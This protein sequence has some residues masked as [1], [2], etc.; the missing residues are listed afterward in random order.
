L[1]KYLR[2]IVLGLAILAG[3]LV[4]VYTAAYIYIAFNKKELILRIKQQAT[5]KLNGDIQIADLSLG[6]LSTFPH[7]S[8]LLENVSV[9][10][11]LFSQHHHPFFAA[12][13]VYINLSI[14]NFIKRDNPINGLRINDGQL[15]VYT[16]TSGYTNAYLFSPK[17]DIKAAA[18]PTTSKTDIENIKLQK[19][20]FVLNDQK[21]LKLYDFDVANYTCNIN[22]TDST[23]KL[24]TDN[25]ILIHSLAFNT[26]AGT[27]LKEAWFKGDY[28]L[29]YNKIK[30][31]LSFNDLDISIKNH[32][33]K[34]SGAFNFTQTPSFSLK[35]STKNLNYDFARSLLTERISTA[36][37]IV[38]LEKPV[39]EV[40]AE[41]SG[42]LK[43]GD[44]LVNATYVCKENNVKSK[45][46]DFTNCSFNG[47]YTNEVVAGLPRKDPN[48][49]L[50]FHNF[51]GNWKNLDIKSK[52]IYI[53]NLFAPMVK[54][55]IKADFDLT[56][57]NTLVASS[58]FDVHKGKG[59][60]DIIFSGPLQQNTRQN[61]L[62]NGKLAFSDGA[63]MYHP[64]NI[65]IKGVNGDIVFRNSDVFVNDFRGIAQGSKIVMNGS[66][67]NLI[68]LLKTDP[69]KM[70]VDWNIYSPSLNLGSFTSLLRKRAGT[71]RKN[72]SGSKIGDYL[73]QVVNQANFHLDIK[74]DQLIYKRFIGTNVRA[75]LGLTNENWLLNN[76]SLNHGGGSMVIRGYLNEKNSRYY[77]SNIKVNMENVDVNKVFYAFNNFGQ[78]GITSENL[79]GKLSSSADINMDIDRNLEEAPTNMSGIIYFS[80]KKGALLHYPPLQKIGD[81]TALTNRNFDE[82]YFAELK[83][84]F[85]L[86]DREIVINRMEI[87]STVLTLFVEG[88][89][90]LR[91]KT[92]I[93]IQVPLSNIGK[94][95]EDAKPGN[96]GTDV[97]AGA[98][99]FIR[100]VPGEDG[101]LKFKLDLFRKFRRDNTEKGNKKNNNK[102]SNDD[103]KK[104]KVS[105]DK[106]KNDKAISNKN[107][108][109]GKPAAD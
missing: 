86:K 10:D 62:L 50:W 19:V 56:Q 36:L 90:S 80:L 91:G 75:S 81:L 43:G 104:D 51:T 65:E 6:F 1:K 49:R 67:K 89:Y 8:V 13:K 69:G 96:K 100:G 66:G 102:E 7:V 37:S 59:L 85:R 77:G 99:I 26:A 94:K 39:N 109:N 35:V 60:L 97:K 73:D 29:T 17:S 30:K 38:K 34:I 70:F 42:P 45:Y 44:P 46:A 15:Y 103:D 3:V 21:K 76:I 88:V 58:T 27:F 68:A 32:P 72:K 54:A 93:S 41:I 11:S 40:N 16:D 24:N 61:T 106:E 53:D 9:K 14:I 25:N 18:K 28:D 52:D 71:I 87:E 74:A 33:F 22:T 31:Q 20:R 63:L 84:T 83:D 55:D 98:S 48:S 79:R 4:F 108:S 5:D 101:N 47:A 82:I 64:R 92:D 57:L 95:D 105:T 12:G 78:N 2:Y 107:N 23:V